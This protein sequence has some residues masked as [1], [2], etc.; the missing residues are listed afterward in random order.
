VCGDTPK[1]LPYTVSADTST[2]RK[3]IAGKRKNIFTDAITDEAV[4]K[5]LM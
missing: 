5:M 2:N 1:R 4:K 3:D